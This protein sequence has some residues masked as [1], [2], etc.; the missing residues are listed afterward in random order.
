VQQRECTGV[1]TE[2]EKGQQQTA[3]KT[4]HQ[5]M[6]TGFKY[7]PE[8]IKEGSRRAAGHVHK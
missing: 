4:A 1:T 2:K 3:A 8:G 7:C 6:N 5:D